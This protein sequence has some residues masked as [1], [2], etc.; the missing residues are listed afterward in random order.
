[1]GVYFG[2]VE[3]LFHKGVLVGVFIS[4]IPLVNWR[5]QRR[6]T[7]AFECMGDFFLFLCCAWCDALQWDEGGCFFSG[8]CVALRWDE[9][10]CFFSGWYD[11]L[12][13]V[14]TAPSCGRSLA[15]HMGCHSPF[16]TRHLSFKRKAPLLSQRGLSS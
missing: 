8:W 5:A 10:G 4:L 12:R 14:G 15:K 1:M 11:A 2:L 7:I 9:G 3:T 6:M 16:A 13:C